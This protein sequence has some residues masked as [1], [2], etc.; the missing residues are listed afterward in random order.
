MTGGHAPGEPSHCYG[1]H[2]PVGEA[3]ARGSHVCAQT[4]ASGI[5]PHSTPRWWALR[6]LVSPSHPRG[7]A[8]SGLPS[9]ESQ[10]CALEIYL[11]LCWFPQLLRPSREGQGAWGRAAEPLRPWVNGRAVRTLLS[12]LCAWFQGGVRIHHQFCKVV[13]SYPDFANR[14]TAQRPQDTGLSSHC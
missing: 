13:F 8:Q 3:E 12:L 2:F 14:E 1:P 4:S 9:P 11:R 5:R 7:Q 6:P 10:G